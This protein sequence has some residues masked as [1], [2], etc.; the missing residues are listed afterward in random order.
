MMGAVSPAFRALLPDPARPVEDLE[1]WYAAAGPLVRAGF[2]QSCDG[3]VSVGGRSD[4]LS[5]PA[6]KAVFRAL[7]A[8]SDAVLVGA[9]T[10]RAEDYGPVRLGPA[11][12][13]WR[14]AAGRAEPPPLVVVTRSCALEPTA[15]CFSGDVRTLVVTCGAAPSAAREGLAEVADVLVAGEDDV[16]LPAMLR[17]LAGRGLAHVLCEGGPA[18]LTDLLAAGLVDELCLTVSPQ[19]VGGAPALLTRGLP[20]R[21]GLSTV[22]LLEADGALLW[23]LA[24]AHSAA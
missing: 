4:P 18:L 1:D 13:R 22:H 5:G 21:V 11:G 8:V 12:L 7:R 23:R 19:L 17:A 16:D 3:A 6:D 10:V 20:A 15:R 2:V 24:V 9:G 14:A